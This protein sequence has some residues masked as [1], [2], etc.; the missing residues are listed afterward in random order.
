MSSVCGCIE[1]GNREGGDGEGVTYSGGGDGEGV[2]YSGGGDGE[3]EVTLGLSRETLSVFG[4][5]ERDSDVARPRPEG[6]G[7][8]DRHLQQL[9][10]VLEVG[11]PGRL[12]V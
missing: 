7:V 1:G 9:S 5:G 4:H 12:C 8:G 3:S 10:I 11:V 2:T 6:G